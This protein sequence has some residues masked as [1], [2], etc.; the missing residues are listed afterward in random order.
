MKTVTTA[1]AIATAGTSFADTKGPSVVVVGA[2]AFGGWTAVYRLR[3]GAKVTLVDAWGPGTSRASFGGETRII[4][5][6]YG[7]LRSIHKWQLTR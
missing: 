6:I 4:R 5:A 7:G 1:T 2:G 3:N